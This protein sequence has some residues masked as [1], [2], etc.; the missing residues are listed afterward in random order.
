MTIYAI[1]SDRAPIHTRY[2]Y[3]HTT[4]TQSPVLQ[5]GLQAEQSLNKCVVDFSVDLV[6]V[7]RVNLFCC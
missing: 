7:W 3:S 5:I 1:S 2:V 6:V 4:T